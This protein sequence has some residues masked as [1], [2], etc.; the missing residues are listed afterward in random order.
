MSCKQPLRSLAPDYSYLS[1]PTPKPVV[2]P[3]AN[4]CAPKQYGYMGGWGWVGIA[5]LLFIIFTVIFW[6]IFYSVAPAFSL[7][8]A[9][10]VDTA[11]VLLAAVVAAIILLLIIWLIKAA[12][13]AATV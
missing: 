9:G 6:I 3:C 8:Q 13:C 2:D 5:I 11:K 4:P 1:C 10:Q 12:F 7:N